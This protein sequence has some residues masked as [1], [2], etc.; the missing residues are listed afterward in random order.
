MELEFE[1]STCRF[2]KRALREVQNQELTQE[3]KLTDGMPDVGRVI[4]SWGQ[5]ILRGKEWRG[6]SIAF[7]GGLMVW[8]LYE[9]EEGGE[10]R[11]LDTWIPFQMKW[12][13]PGNVNEGDIR[14]RSL[15]RFTD[16]RSV[17]PRKIMI[18]AGV[19]ALA[20]AMCP[21]QM[22]VYIPG[23]V[24]ED[25]QLLSKTYPVRLPVEAGEKAFLMDE[26]L[27]LPG[28]SPAPEK[29]LYYTVQPQVTDTKVMS[30]KVVFRGNGNL[31]MLYRAQ[32]GQLYSWDFELPFSQFGE[33]EGEYSLE[34]QG[35][36]AMGTTNLELE[37]DDEG[38]MRLKCG[39]VGQYLVDD[40][41]MM[42]IVEDSY[43]PLRPVEPRMQPLELPAVLDSRSENI[44]GEQTIPADANVI[45]DSVYL[46]DYPRQRRTAD[47]MEAEIPGMFQV[48]Y[49]GEDGALRSGTARWEGQWAMKADGGSSIA[50]DVAPVGRPLASIGDGS[51]RMQSETLVRADTVSDQGL[52]MVT[53]LEMGQLQEPDP[54]RPSVILRRMGDDD[55]WS[56]A[57]GSGSTVEA[58][59]QANGFQEEPERGRMLLIPVM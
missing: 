59:R 51:I 32:D 13:L 17:S 14:I 48:L 53:G 25:I 58:I 46:P 28:S 22:D 45:V 55:L 19:A 6:D 5:V 11:C 1:K 10:M 2:L 52:P 38:H 40:R 49:Y 18:R 7:S 9:P 3:I 56:M 54:M 27:V 50:M 42:Q 31:H 44:Y 15:V 43:S 33:L 26:E 24:P 41:Q 36:I 34:A 37:M 35:E 4:G 21:A 16:A 57:K 39:L 8:V 12:D 30:N 47:G 29:I 23:E 20:E